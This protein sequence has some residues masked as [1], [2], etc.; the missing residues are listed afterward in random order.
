MAERPWRSRPGGQADAG[1]ILA[2]R[3]EVF[4]DV[5]AHKL[6]PDVWRWQFQDNPAGAGW[7][8]LADH[9]GYV[10]GQYAAI[11]TRFRVRGTERTFALSCDT[12]TH[13]RYQKQGIFVQLARD[14]YDDVARE[15]GVDVVWGFPNDS[16]RPGFVGKLDWFD[17]HT[18]P[19]YVKPIES[20]HVLRRYLPSDGLARVLGAVGDAV[21]RTV[22]PKP[23]PPRRATIRRLTGFDDR[24]QALWER[25]RDIAPV[26]QVRDPAYLHWRYIAMPLFEYEPYEVVVDGR[27]E[28][29]LVLRTLTLFDLPFTALVDLFPLPLVDPEVTREVLGFAQQ[30][31]VERRSAFLTALV[32]PAHAQYLTRFGFLR[33]PDSLNPRRWYLGARCRPDDT[34]L[35]RDIGSWHIT[36]GDADIV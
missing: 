12:M 26:A 19:I 3:R 1:A 8:R 2:L 28:G 7:I 10:C 13:P 15:H 9:E 29:L 27:L 34:S 6:R 4:G 21:Y 18:F 25:H 36:Y 22:A 16:S 24:F 30:R 20:R 31:A 23:R 35:L 11:P 17:V 14:L 32:S 5:D 33:I